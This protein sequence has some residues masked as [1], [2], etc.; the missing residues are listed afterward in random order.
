MFTTAM[1]TIDCRCKNSHSPLMLDEIVVWRDGSPCVEGTGVFPPISRVCPV[2]RQPSLSKGSHSVNHFLF[3]E[4]IFWIFL[5]QRATNDTLLEGKG[6]KHHFPSFRCALTLV[7]GHLHPHRQQ[8]TC[9]IRML[10]ANKQAHDQGD[11]ERKEKT[12]NQK[13]TKKMAFNY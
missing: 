12:P 2:T 9:E 1:C 8:A 5:L 10:E 11:D 4:P 13:K 7:T 3:V 6:M